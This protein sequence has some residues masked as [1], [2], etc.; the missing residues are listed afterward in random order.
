[1]GT[2]KWHSASTTAG[3]VIHVPTPER[4]ERSKK[5]SQCICC[6]QKGKETSSIMPEI[7]NSCPFCSLPSSRIISEDSLSWVIRDAYPISPGHSLII[8]KRHIASLFELTD[9]ERTSLFQNLSKAKTALDA[10]FKPDGYNIGINEG[11]GCRS[12]RISSSGLS[13]ICLSEVS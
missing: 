12:N 13:Q 9:D 11:E 1:M 3:A 2:H 4:G 5:V 10:E 7:D 6:E 8:P